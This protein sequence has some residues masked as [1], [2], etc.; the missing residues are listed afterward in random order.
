MIK[1][2]KEE[3]YRPEKIHYLNSLEFA[4]KMTDDNKSKMTFHCFWRVPRDF[5]RKQ[6]AVLKSI[7]VNHINK[8]IEINLWSNVDLST[9]EFFKE[10]SEHV[11]LKL[12]NINEEIKG[13][14]LEN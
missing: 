4:K 7:I 11:N 12:W 10:L 3:L 2:L 5:G 13:T 1:L 8:N 6:V 9:N 14:I